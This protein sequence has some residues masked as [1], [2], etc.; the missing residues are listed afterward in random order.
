[1]KEEKLVLQQRAQP[2]EEVIKE[3][4][5]LMPNEILKQMMKQP[6]NKAFTQYN[7]YNVSRPYDLIELDLL[8]LPKD[9]KYL[10]CLCA[11]DAASRYKWAQPIKD[12]TALSVLNAFISMKLP[13]NKIGFINT[14]S[15]SEFHGDFQKYLKQKKVQQR[16][17]LPSHHLSF[18]ESFNGTL[19]RHLFL[20]LQEIEMDTGEFA[21]EWTR[22]LQN[23][24]S[25][26]NNSNTQMIKMKPID[27]I[28]LDNVPQ[29]KNKI[30]GNDTE[31][32]YMIG[33]IV[34]KMYNKDEIYDVSSKTIKVERRRKTDPWFSKEL[35]YVY[36]VMPTSSNEIGDN[37]SLKYHW[38]ISIEKPPSVDNVYEHAYT[39][40]Q[41]QPVLV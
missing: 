37:N 4:E 14:D 9:K 16:F 23:V 12:K 33:T 15:G 2:A 6:P 22:D 41:L 25:M 7:H 34:R 26:L 30:C 18:V 27:A 11:I 13:L 21:K 8:F 31:K 19:A 17:N 10:Y 5:E 24:V 1:M 39:Y 20:P 35:Y 36:D 29:P 38:I 3:L 32:Q 28:K 40:F